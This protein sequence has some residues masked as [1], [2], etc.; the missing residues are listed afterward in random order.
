[1]SW[2]RR[3]VLWFVAMDRNLDL[4]AC[5]PGVQAKPEKFELGNF[6][7]PKSRLEPKMTRNDRHHP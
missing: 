4:S 3:L 1:M 5:K 2:L 7:L 6:E